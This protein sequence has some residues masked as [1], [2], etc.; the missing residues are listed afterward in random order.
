MPARRIPLE[1]IDGQQ[2]LTTLVKF[3]S[4]E[5]VLQKLQSMASLNGK[6]FEN[7]ATEQQEKILDTPIRSIVIDAAGNRDLRYEVFERLNRGSMIRNEQ[8]V[9]NCVYRL[10]FNDLL[11]EL[12]TKTYWRKAKGGDAP[13]G[14]FTEREL[15]LRF[16]AFADRFHQYAGGLEPFLNEYMG[17][18]AP[19]TRKPI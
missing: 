15:I 4:N 3:V 16:F 9:R 19:G 7:L 2:R 6:L 13:E 10:P 12:E 14:R 18:Y 5:F 8:E 11:G 1:V 17:R